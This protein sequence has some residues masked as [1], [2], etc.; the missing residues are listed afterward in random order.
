MEKNKKAD[1]RAKSEKLLMERAPNQFLQAD[2]GDSAGKI[3]LS[4]S[5]G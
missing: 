1:E 3:E 4:A 2:R 5:R